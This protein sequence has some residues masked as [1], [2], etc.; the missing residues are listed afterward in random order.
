MPLYFFNVYDGY[1]TID[2]EGTELHDWR[3]AR[4]EAIRLTGHILRDEAGRLMPDKEWKMEVTDAAGSI[5]FKL[6]FSFT[7]TPEVW[8][9]RSGP[10][11]QAPDLQPSAEL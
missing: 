9:L 2:M 6:D 4:R 1:S 5:L 3:S 11:S 7:D 8:K 10:N